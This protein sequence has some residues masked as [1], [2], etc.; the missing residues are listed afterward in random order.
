[1]MRSKCITPELARGPGAGN[2]ARMPRLFWILCIGLLF[3]A[4][5]RADEVSSRVVILA[6]SDEPESVKLAEYYAEKRDV[7]KANIIALPM[8]II[9]AV[10]WRSFVDTV[11]N[12]LQAE[13]V[14]RGWIDAI[15]MDLTDTAGRKKYVMG[16]HKISYLVVCRGVPLKVLNEPLLPAEAI[17][18][19]ANPAFR[20]NAASV[21]GEL[22]LLALSN[23]PLIAFVPN[24][25]FKNDRP[26]SIE[27]GQIVKVSRLDGPS[28]PDA[29][30]LIDNALEAERSGLIGR[31]YIDIGG[32]H[33]AGDQW[34]E[35]AATQLAELNYDGDVDRAGGSMGAGA[36]MDMPAL[37]F[38]W[39]AG[40]LN[41]PFARDGFLFPTGAVALHIHSYSADTLRSTTRGWVG[42][43][44]ARGVTAT[45]GNVT[46]PYLEL[47]HQ[48]QLLLKSLARGDRWGDAAAYAVPVFSWQAM[49]VG[50]PLYR[51]FKV[52]FEEQWARRDKLTPEQRAYVV[53]RRMRELDRGGDRNAAI[54]AGLT[55]EKA[56]HHLAVAL[57]AAKLQIAAE[58]LSGARQTLDWVTSRRSFT[59]G[60]SATVGVIAQTLKDAGDA[61]AAVLVW[62][63]VLGARDIQRDARVAWLPQAIEVA[64]AAQ[65]ARQVIYWE[66]EYKVLTA[67][68][69]DTGTK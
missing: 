29:R 34:L 32:P 24:P 8:P 11:F 44:V 12:P 10:S 15:G 53:L 69:P 40:D 7:P 14:T 28:F 27:L 35:E 60:E 1:M 19:T 43:L 38:G 56:N 31:S 18:L 16:G 21:D 9:E 23:T 49:A 26:S 46:E 6:N 13:L 3:S 55:A 25:L 48:P 30:K 58:D 50:D 33:K 68:P 37:Y 63:A 67:P 41:G 45:V 51:P 4:G 42:P 36:R 47:T 2:V 62:R 54:W 65:D 20:T 52:T 17:P 59:P 5:A 22:A 66:E 61:K 57:A 64:R 39:Y